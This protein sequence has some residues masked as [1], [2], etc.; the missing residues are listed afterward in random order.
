M[1]DIGPFIF[2]ACFPHGRL[3]SWDASI[4]CELDALFHVGRPIVIRTIWP[5]IFPW[6]AYLMSSRIE[7]YRLGQ[8]SFASSSSKNAAMLS[9]L[10]TTL[11][12][13]VCFTLSV[14]AMV[15]VG[16]LAG[17]LLLA[18]RRGIRSFPS[19]GLRWS[20]NHSPNETTM[21]SGPNAGY[22]GRGQTKPG[23]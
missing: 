9:T 6:T 12:W 2:D 23:L 5:W 3:P 16:I 11:K 22:P 17:M 1:I 19:S 14:L 8:K 15:Q 18:H 10:T 13:M 7:R 4:Y 20:K 21:W